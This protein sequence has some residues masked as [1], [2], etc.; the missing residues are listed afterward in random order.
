VVAA[1]GTVLVTGATD[2][3]GRALAG[4]LLADGYRV[5]LHGRDAQR[6]AATA[7]RLGVP[8][9][10]TVLADLAQLAQ[11]R[12]L[13]TAVLERYDRL[14][15]LVN[16]A[17]VGFGAPGAARE[18]SADGY[19]LRLA[20]NFLAPYLLTRLLADRLRA[21][22]PARVV[23]VA[24]VGQRPVDFD[25]PMLVRGYDGAEAYR[26]SKLAL[27]AFT[28]SMAQRLAGTGVDVNALH[29]ATL[30]PTT[31]VTASRY[32]ARSSLADG[33][34]A[35]LRLVTDPALARVTGEYFDGLEPAR[36]RREVYDAQ[37][38]DRLWTLGARLTGL[39]D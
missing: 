19:E 25:D 4:A 11:V 36:A 34:R 20:V 31:M 6:L 13:A 35:T 23:N 9:G 5:L 8:A 12:R 30:M 7:A 17:G 16:N 22:A 37:V 1:A 21:C 18:E 33:L 38:R 26:R 15:V 14:D 28:V 2:G 39:P 29:P 24:S 32:P 3:L 27:V 10:D